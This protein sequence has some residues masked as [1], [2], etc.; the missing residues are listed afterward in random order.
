M[1]RSVLANIP[2]PSK[3]GKFTT[4][5]I[6]ELNN[7]EIAHLNKLAKRVRKSKNKTL[8]EYTGNFVINYKRKKYLLNLFVGKVKRNY[9]IELSVSNTENIKSIKT[10]NDRIFEQIYNSIAQC[11]NR[12]KE[13]YI[14]HESIFNSNKVKPTFNT[15]I[16]S[17]A[18]EGNAKFEIL[19]IRTGIRKKEKM[20]LT[21]VID[22]SDDLRK[23]RIFVKTQVK[24]RLN[25][26]LFNTWFTLVDDAMKLYISGRGG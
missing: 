13:I 14:Y 3:F 16:F 23:I 26:R 11:I 2:D 8:T 18:I 15:P 24:T 5:I 9:F 7:K 21:S 4:T 19:G 17:E 20:K 6:L 12:P 22:F 1:K 25:E 10:L